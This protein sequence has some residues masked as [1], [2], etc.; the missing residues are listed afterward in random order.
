MDDIYHAL[1]NQI[2]SL[3][4]DVTLLMLGEDRQSLIASYMSYA[5]GLIRKLEKLTGSSAIGYRIAVSQESIYAR[6]IASNKAEYVQSAKQ[7]F[8]DAFPKEF[9][10]VAEKIIDILNVGAGDLAPVAC[11]RRDSG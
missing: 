2:K 8:Y 1:G 5:P 3:G 9:R 7:H 11:G 4:G 6:D 10:Y